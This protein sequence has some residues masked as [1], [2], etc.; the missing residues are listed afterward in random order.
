MDDNQAAPPHVVLD[1]PVDVRG[2]SLAV[3]A[4]LASVYILKWASAVFV[5]V[6]LGLMLSY[7][8]SPIVDRLRR[9][10]IPRA[11]GAA[12]LLTGIVVGTGSL[13]YSLGDEGA[14]LVE[15]LPETAQK[16]RL[17]LQGPRQAPPG[18][19][20]NVQK[21][22]A[23]LARVADE[24]ATLDSTSPRGVTHVVVERPRFNV[25]EYLWT[26]TLGLVALLGQTAMVILIAYFLL[27]SGDSFRRK[28]VKIAGP[29]LSQKR[30]TLDALDEINGQIQRYLLVQLLTSVIVG[31]A[32]WLA[33]AWIGLQNA[34]V[35][36]VVAAVTNL[37]P[38]LGAAIVG[39]GSAVMGFIQFGRLDMALVIGGA[40][41][42]IHSVVGYV[43]TP[44]MTSRA[45]RMN[46]VTV[47]I[48]VIAGGWLWGLPGLV[49]G[50]PILMV[51][52]AVCDRVED[53]NPIGELLGS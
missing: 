1:V 24:D 5:P 29:R 26:G 38:Y 47:F 49:L 9:W 22:A 44:W 36:G 37:I 13:L 2:V 42:A 15:S 46:P 45:G 34:A 6:L 41:F 23:E 19:I 12:V 25:K 18:T 30:I 28:L 11:L 39:A 7:A 31:V 8:L 48:A 32:T 51:V 21:A 53:L 35:W 50:V 17:S 40:S 3:L 10:R 16:L 4:V 14:A 20:V 43:L 27:A 33:F 52:K